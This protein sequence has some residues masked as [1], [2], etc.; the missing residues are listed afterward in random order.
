MKLIVVMILTMIVMGMLIAMIIIVLGKRVVFVR[1]GR[2]EHV[3]LMKVLVQAGHKAVRMET[4]ESVL[5]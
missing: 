3:V 5:V 1:A 4:G 2:R